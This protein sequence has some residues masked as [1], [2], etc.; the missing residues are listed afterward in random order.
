MTQPGIDPATGLPPGVDPQV[1]EAM[2]SLARDEA[3]GARMTLAIGPYAAF[4]MI[5]AIQLAYRHPS[6]DCKV[7][8]I[9]R[10]VGGQLEAMFA[11]GPL[12]Q[13]LADGWNRDKDTAGAHDP[14]GHAATD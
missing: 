12:Q 14:G 2:K 13:M 11:G 6:M 7:G 3:A 9:L 1:W 8:G 10:A 5:G 4:T